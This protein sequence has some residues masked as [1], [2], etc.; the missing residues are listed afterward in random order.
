MPIYEYYSPDTDTVYSF[1]VRDASKAGQAPLC[2]D[3]SGHRMEKRISRFAVLKNRGEEGAEDGLDDPRMEAAMAQLESEFAG[4]DESDPDPRQMG[5]MMRRLEELAGRK[6]PESMREMMARLEAG[7][8]PEALEEAFG[9]DLGEGG[10]DD[11]E[12]EDF[13][14][15]GGG[16]GAVRRLLRAARGPKVDPELY[17]YSDFDPSAGKAQAGKGKKRS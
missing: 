1:L 12:M 13:F 3:G 10:E 11:D 9:D 17:D 15:P 6:L 4:M 16:S 2:P 8:D 14:A 7:E 5:R